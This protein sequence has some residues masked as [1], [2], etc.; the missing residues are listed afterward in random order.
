MHLLVLTLPKRI[1]VYCPRAWGTHGSGSKPRF[2]G[3]MWGTLRALRRTR[4]WQTTMRH[5][6]VPSVS[7]SGCGG[8]PAPG[9]GGV[10]TRLCPARRV[11]TRQSCGSPSRRSPQRW[12]GELREVSV[13]LSIQKRTF[14]T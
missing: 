11:P 3:A 13:H 1:P 7:S 9:T 10:Q 4:D 2:C 14:L 5:L 12:S 8:V 6:C